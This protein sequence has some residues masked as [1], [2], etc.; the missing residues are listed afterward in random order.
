[1]KGWQPPSETEQNH[2]HVGGLGGDTEGLDDTPHSTEPWCSPKMLGGQ[3]SGGLQQQ[4]L[5]SI[6]SGVIILNYTDSI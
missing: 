6:F 5:D 3:R 4:M 2:Q 1:M